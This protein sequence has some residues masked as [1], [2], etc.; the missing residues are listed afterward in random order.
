MGCTTKLVLK[1][2]WKENAKYMSN[3]SCYE[4]KFKEGS[5]SKRITKKKMKLTLIAL[6]R[7]RKEASST[8]STNQDSEQTRLTHQTIWTRP[9]EPT[10]PSPQMGDQLGVCQI[11]LKK[12][13]SFL[14]LFLFSSF[15]RH[16]QFLHQSGLNLISRLLFE[17]EL[18]S[19]QS[20]K[21]LLNLGRETLLTSNF[22][23]SIQ[24]CYIG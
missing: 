24:A 1:K 9:R 5:E 13:I 19:F 16:A 15:D 4:K 8:R 21:N 20:S 14:F 7:E 3:L 6:R 2:K 23:F 12:A 11:R 22:L 18:I 17:G 10:S